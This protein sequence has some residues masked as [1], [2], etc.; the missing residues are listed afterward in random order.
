MFHTHGRPPRPLKWSRWVVVDPC[1]RWHARLCAY[2]VREHQRGRPLSEILT[3]HFVVAHASEAAITHLLTDPQLI[4]R[5]ASDCRDFPRLVQ[6]PPPATSR[7]AATE[8]TSADGH[9][10]ADHRS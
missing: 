10:G 7:S 3:D 8:Q 9:N 4:H 6:S 2:I 1:R 5:L